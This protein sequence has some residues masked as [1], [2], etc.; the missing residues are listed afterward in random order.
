[1][2]LE[3]KV[4]HSQRVYSGIEIPMELGMVVAGAIRSVP[5]NVTALPVKTKK[6]QWRKAVAAVAVVLLCFT[7]GLNAS[8]AFA[9]AVSK[10]PVLGDLSRVLT[11]R[12]YRWKDND[13]SMHIAVPQIQTEEGESSALVGDVN[14]EIERIVEAYEEEAEQHIAEYKEAFLA[15]GGTEEEFAEKNIKVNVD[16]SVRYESQ[17]CLSLVL[18]ADEDWSGAYGVQY[19]YNLDLKEGRKLT[20]RDL[21]G[22]DYVQI[23]NAEIKRQMQAR[24][25]ADPELTYFDGSN[26]MQGFTTVDEYTNFYISQKGNPVVVFEKYAIAP[27]AF[28]AQE[29]EIPVQP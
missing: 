2:N 17:D 4:L 28:G 13:K 3:Q 27:G 8:E 22:D 26:G 10:V 18:S 15:T 9:E 7:A 11:F 23:A 14:A 19:Y 12:E 20:L 1:M 5:K 21:L 6:T 29:F 24:L 25:T 16:Y